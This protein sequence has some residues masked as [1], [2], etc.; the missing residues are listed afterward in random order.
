LKGSLTDYSNKKKCTGD[1]GHELTGLKRVI[2]TP[3]FFT[4]KQHGEL[5]K[6]K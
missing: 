1:S 2:V 3:S 5:R 6:I 4:E